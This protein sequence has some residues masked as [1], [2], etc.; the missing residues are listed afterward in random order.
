VAVSVTNP[1]GRT[2]LALANA[3][4]ARDL[5]GAA[6]CFARDARFITPDTTLI[7]G[8]DGI[9][10]ILAQLINARAQIEIEASSLVCLGEVALGAERWCIRFRGVN[11]SPLRQVWPEILMAIHRIEGSWKFAI[12]APWGFGDLDKRDTSC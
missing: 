3:I 6:N 11:G 12:A 5:D 8:R 10:P 7:R 9:R 4:S 2:S 1:P